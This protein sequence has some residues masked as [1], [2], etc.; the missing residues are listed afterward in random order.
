MRCPRCKEENDRVIGTRSAR[1]GSAVR[2]RRECRSCGARV[3]TFEEISDEAGPAVVDENGKRIKPSNVKD[4]AQKYIDDACVGLSVNPYERDRAAEGIALLAKEYGEAL[5]PTRVFFGWLVEMLGELHEVARV[6]FELS[7]FAVD[8]TDC[9]GIITNGIVREC[10]RN[11]ELSSGI[12]TETE[13]D[14]SA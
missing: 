11:V 12:R 9:V 7:I 3:T 5:V 2:R 1:E 8:V 10:T 14:I 13:G 6:R 4:R